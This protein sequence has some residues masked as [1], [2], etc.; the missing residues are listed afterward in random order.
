MKRPISQTYLWSSLHLILLTGFS[1]AESGKKSES[2]HPI[3]VLTIRYSDDQSRGHALA[4][5]GKVT[6]WLKNT[7]KVAVDGV[8]V[9]AQ[10][11]NSL[12]HRVETVS[13]PIDLLE[14]G[15][16]MVI[17]IPWDVIGEKNL[18]PK[19]YVE[20]KGRGNRT[21]RFKAVLLLDPDS[22]MAYEG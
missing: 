4:S 11:C 3:V 15:E 22:L 16:K 7:A 10:L 13:E 9:D 19:I 6:V 17:T 1:S 8:K 2:G 21:V 5:K 20:Y 14:A 18:K 12:G